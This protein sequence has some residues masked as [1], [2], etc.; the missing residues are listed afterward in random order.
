M[1]DIGAK[2]EIKSVHLS[3]II[4]LKNV[5]NS[6]LKCEHG[7]LSRNGLRPRRGACHV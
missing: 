7:F 5:L 2:R 4:L 1:S 3:C 6:H